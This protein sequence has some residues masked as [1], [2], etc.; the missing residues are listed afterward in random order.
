MVYYLIF[1]IC[2][3]FILRILYS[4]WHHGKRKKADRNMETPGPEQA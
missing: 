3:E 1:V 4:G 2:L